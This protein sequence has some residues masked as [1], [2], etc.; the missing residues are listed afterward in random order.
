MYKSFGKV[1]LLFLNGIKNYLFPEK[2]KKTVIYCIAAS[3]LISVVFFLNGIIFGSLLSA[4]AFLIFLYMFVT[5]PKKA[6]KVNMSHIERS[7]SDSFMYTVTFSENGAEIKNHTENT[8]SNAE[9]YMF[10]VLVETDNAYVI[11]TRNGN[12]IPVFKE[13]IGD[14]NRKEFLRYLMSN[15]P[16]LKLKLKKNKKFYC[17]F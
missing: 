1:D 8:V 10:S 9:F 5:A 16:G 3:L 4:A 12:F 11:F 2:K 6:V 15:A 17:H 13:Y 7:G 14:G